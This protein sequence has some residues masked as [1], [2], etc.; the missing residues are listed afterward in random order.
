[1]KKTPDFLGAYLSPHALI[2]WLPSWSRCW[3]V[4]ELRGLLTWWTAALLFSRVWHVSYISHPLLPSRVV[5][6]S[7]SRKIKCS[8]INLHIDHTGHLLAHYWS[9]TLRSTHCRQHLHIYNR[10]PNEKLAHILSC[11]VEAFPL[12]KVETIN[13]Y[14][15][16]GTI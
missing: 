15:L 12:I 7:C 2:I 16:C 6:W 11:I 1:M 10:E 3:T 5:A 14:M 8:I 9:D 4:Q 13:L